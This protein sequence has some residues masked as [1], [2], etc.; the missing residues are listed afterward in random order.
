MD[1]PSTAFMTISI[2]CGCLIFFAMPIIIQ[3]TTYVFPSFITNF[4]SKLFDGKTLQYFV[5]F[6][7]IFISIPLLLIF[8]FLKGQNILF[9]NN[10]VLIYLVIVT[11]LFFG[12][13]LLKRKTDYH[14]Y[15]FIFCFLFFVLI[16]PVFI[17]FFFLG[18]SPIKLGSPNN[19]NNYSVFFITAV[20]IVYFIILFIFFILYFYL[21]TFKLA[22][23]SFFQS[24][25]NMFEHLFIQ[26][27]KDIKQINEN[28]EIKNAVMNETKQTIPLFFFLF[29][30]ILITIIAMKD[31]TSSGK[32]MNFYL[33]MLIIPLGIGLYITKYLI[34]SSGK[35]SS[36][37]FKAIITFVVFSF[38]L[39]GIMYSYSINPLQL[40]FA[41]SIFY[42]LFALIA[43]VGLAI[44]FILFAEYFKN[45]DG[46]I[47][48]FVNIL[49]FIPCLFSDFIEYIKH[50]LNITPSTIYILFLFEICLVLFYYYIPKLF[51]Y[52]ISRNS[53]VLLKSPQYLDTS[54]IIADSSVFQLDN[55]KFLQN[56]TYKINNHSF[57]FW[58]YMN[59]NEVMQW[60][61]ETKPYEYTLLHY[62]TNEKSTGSGGKPKVVYINDNN[63]FINTYRVYVNND[64][65]CDSIDTSNN[66]FI[67]LDNIPIQRWNFFVINFQ[68]SNV[69]I[70]VNGE[71]SQ[72]KSDNKKSGGDI[73][74]D[75]TS[76]EHAN[77]SIG[78]E[79]GVNGAIC[80]VYYHHNPL[81]LFEIVNMYNIE[82]Y[83]VMSQ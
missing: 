19:N 7:V 8:V 47:G 64:N 45:M 5:T 73:Y 17:H 34:N 51:E 82:K 52:F 40:V 15:A 11:F 23:L 46:M 74:L 20:Y 28:I 35:D 22:F 12:N 31:N 56:N 83:A 26:I 38:I 69:D 60:A 29:F 41:Y 25:W 9:M 48:I 63:H 16:F 33:F 65:K 77:V 61:D 72:T 54:R 36:L 43:I 6:L 71:L 67:Q 68:E 62:K 76:N 49:F 13:L 18:N 14:M 10:F 24:F 78:H 21:D 80:N 58:I 75:D 55:M 42:F 30:F 32:N 2:I 44:V 50:E 57:S 39:T 27:K 3:K 79:N 81:S 66:C 4:F 53:I 70:F 59:K 37:Y 1:A